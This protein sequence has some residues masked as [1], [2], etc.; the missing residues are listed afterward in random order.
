MRIDRSLQ[1]VNDVT[2]GVILLGTRMYMGGEKKISS[3]ANSNVLVLFN[4]RSM[5]GYKSVK[6]MVEPKAKTP[7]GNHFAFVHVNIPKISSSHYLSLDPLHFVL[8]VHNDIDR[9]KNNA[10]S[11]L[12]GLLLDKLRIFKGPEVCNISI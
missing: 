8:Q 2:T 4:T 9:K 6:E 12:S 1:T 11:F 5:S 10:S 7:W 3:E